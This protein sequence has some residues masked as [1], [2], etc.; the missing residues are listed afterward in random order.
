MKS[1]SKVCPSG[2]FF[3]KDVVHASLL[4]YPCSRV[5]L[6]SVTPKVEAFCQLTIVGKVS[7]VDNLKR[8]GLRCH[9]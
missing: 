1:L 9:F 5:W 6:G 7:T 8:D 2:K 4:H 3:C